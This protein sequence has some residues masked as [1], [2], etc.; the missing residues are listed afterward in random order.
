MVSRETLIGRQRVLAEFGNFAL[1]RGDLQE[2]LDEAC[3]LVGEALD[4]E[5]S[6]LVVR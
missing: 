3:R 4:T 6:K 2:V 1:R 5:L